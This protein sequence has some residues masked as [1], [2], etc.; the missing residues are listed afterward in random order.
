MGM[1][2]TSSIVFACVAGGALLGLFL[3]SK[4]P[5]HHLCPESREVVKLGMGLIGTMTALLLG[6]QIGAAKNTFDSADTRVKEIA[7]KIGFLDRVM[8]MYGPETQDSREALRTMVAGGLDTIW[9]PS[10]GATA[11]PSPVEKRGESLFQ[12]LLELTPD[13]PTKTALKAE[14]ITLATEVARIR[15]LMFAQSKST[16]SFVF[17]GIVV[18]WL[19]VVFVSFGLLGRPNATVVTTLMVCALS[20][21][22]AIGLITELNRPFGGYI[23]ISSEPLRHAL[24][25]MGS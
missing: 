18:F 10:G 17:L 25:L 12:R 21:S 11:L 2:I 19:S 20:V 13:H 6:M 15:W 4:L 24:S 3:R 9:P 23:R 14:A 16:G 5:P 22:A 7:S 8:A 1:I